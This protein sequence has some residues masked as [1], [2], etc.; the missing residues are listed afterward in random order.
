[1][2]LEV[3]RKI[4]IEHELVADVAK[5]YGVTSSCIS[6]IVSTMRKDP[7][8]IV[9]RVKKETAEALTDEALAEFVD[10]KLL[11][12]EL[13]ERAED[14]KRDYEAKAGVQLKI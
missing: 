5:E 8:D 9:D 11:D 4:A 6:R 13:I 7:T 12:G 2:R 1:M 10:A 14:V 3:A